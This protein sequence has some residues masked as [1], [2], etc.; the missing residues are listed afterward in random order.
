MAFIL[1]PGITN[2]PLWAKSGTAI[3][4]LLARAAELQDQTQGWPSLTHILDDPDYQVLLNQ[5]VFQSGLLE[6]NLLN[7]F[8]PA[9]Q[10]LIII[11]FAAHVYRF[12]MPA[13]ANVRDAKQRVK[14]QLNPRLRKICTF[15]LRIT[16]SPFR[17]E[18]KTKLITLTR[19]PYQN[20]CFDLVSEQPSPTRVPELLSVNETVFRKHLWQSRFQAGVDQGLWRLVSIN[21]PH[22]VIALGTSKHNP[23][24]Y[25][26]R[27]RL[28][29]YPA[30]PP[31]VELWNEEHQASI[32]PDCW[33]AWFNHFITEAYP[34]LVA[35]DPTSYSTELLQLS[36]SIATLKCHAALASWDATGDLTQC[37]AP[38]VGHLW[39]HWSRRKSSDVQ[40]KRGIRSLLP[41][42]QRAQSQKA[43]AGPR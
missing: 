6:G 5:N 2:I 19:L 22:V 31:S 17:P 12:R 18:G 29:D 10:L 14:K 39:S 43:V 40:Q 33:P 25:F 34:H 21:W 13:S 38:M 32:S 36:I 4:D 30:Q 9:R 24:E 20:L 8:N 23:T 3:G 27:F 15:E 11:S 1:L 42:K 35:V 28:A 37:L 7:I 16:G 41:H 26:I